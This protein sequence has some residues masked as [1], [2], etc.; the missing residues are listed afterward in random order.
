[1]AIEEV[2]DTIALNVTSGDNIIEALA[3][4]IGPALVKLGVFLGGVGLLYLILILVRV[5]YEREKV[6]LL[7]DIRYNQMQL[8][9]HYGVRYTMHKPNIIIRTGRK[10]KDLFV[11]SRMKSDLKKKIKSKLKR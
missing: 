3:E 1:M 10:I 5:Y 2:L 6:N 7:K 9:K 8:N 11:S 4:G